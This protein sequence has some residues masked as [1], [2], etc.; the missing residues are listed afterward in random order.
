M[1]YKVIFTA[2]RQTPIRSHY[3]PNWISDSKPEQNCAQLLFTDK[4]MIVDGESHECILEP[5]AVNLWGS[6]TVGD[7][8]KCMEG[9]R[10]VGTAIV[11]EIL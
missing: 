2:N 8:L 3:R 4:T 5:F 1:K 11:L 10:E 9:F 7:V 6:V